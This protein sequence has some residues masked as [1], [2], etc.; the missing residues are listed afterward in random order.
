[1]FNERHRNKYSLTLDLGHSKGKGIFKEL[2][3]IS[4]VVVEN[5]SVTVMRNLGLDYP[6]LR[7]SNPT[8]VMISMSGHGTTGP[9]S[10]YRSYGSTLEMLSGSAMLTGYPDGAPMHS[11]NYYPDP[12]AGMLA[13]GLVVTALLNRRRTGQGMFIDLS[14]RELSTHLIGDA[15]MEYSM[16]KRLLPRIGNRHPS[17]A[18][19]GCYRCKGEDMWV[20][21]SVGSNDEW[22]ALCGV[23]GKPEL[24]EDD[25]F[26]DIVSRYNSQGDLD[27]IIEAWTVEQDHCEAMRIL[28]DAGV[29][30]GAVLTAPELL[31]DPHLDDR[32][33]FEVVTHPEAGTFPLRGML[34]KLSKT[35]G[36]IR[37]PA[38]CFG[39]HNEYVLGELL[40][41]SKDEI[42]RLYEEGVITTVPLEG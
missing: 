33:F 12:A 8:I 39:E 40:C 31:K 4:D 5:F 23:I 22:N 36:S 9:E 3:K 15:F 32:G 24:A 16:N 18:P 38:P 28:Q 37:R 11:G 42:D 34:W 35:P 30:A 29:P 19:H 1:M 20:A 41:I 13:A 27:R 7:E 21:I 25:R 10:E 2:V 14:Q 17:M 26:S 6:V